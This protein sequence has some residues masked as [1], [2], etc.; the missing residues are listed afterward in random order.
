MAHLSGFTLK[1]GQRLDAR[2]GF[3]YCCWWLFCKGGCKNLAILSQLALG[4]MKRN[5]FQLFYTA[6][7]VILQVTLQGTL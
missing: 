5:L 3:G 1:P 7:S 4:T 6:Y 2:S